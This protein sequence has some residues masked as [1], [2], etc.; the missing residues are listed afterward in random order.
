[1]Q[2]MHVVAEMSKNTRRFPVEI[3]KCKLPLPLDR[4][5]QAALGG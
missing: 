5:N 1:M 4:I 2:N 3:A